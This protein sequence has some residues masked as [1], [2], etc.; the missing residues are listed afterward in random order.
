MSEIIFVKRNNEYRVQ[1]RDACTEGME[2]ISSMDVPMK[3]VESLLMR[4]TGNKSGCFY[5]NVPQGDDRDTLA[6][7][8]FKHIVSDMLGISK[9]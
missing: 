9:G 6:R 7:Y 8:M 4:I 3:M 5:I 2:I 1:S